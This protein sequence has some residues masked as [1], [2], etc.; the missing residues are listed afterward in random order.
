MGRWGERELRDEGQFQPFGAWGVLRRRQSAPVG[1]GA[2]EQCLCLVNSARDRVNDITGDLRWHVLCTA[3]G[4]YHGRDAG[5]A[6][7]HALAFEHSYE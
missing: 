7:V 6:S 4:A 5:H 3:P 1:I 2:L